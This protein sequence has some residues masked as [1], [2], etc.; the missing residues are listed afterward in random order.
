MSEPR[1]PL[2]EAASGGAVPRWVRCCTIA[3]V[4]VGCVL[5]FAGISSKVIWNDE[6]HTGQ[7][8][9]GATKRELR[10]RVFDGRARSRDEVLA[11]QFP[12]SG[13][14]AL[15]TVAVLARDDPKHPPLYFVTVRAWMQ[16]FGAS[17]GV[18]RSLSAVFGVVALPLL[19][20][21]CR[22]LAGAGVAPW[23]AVALVSVSPIHLVYAQEARQYTLW[24]DLVLLASWCL[25]RGVRCARADG[26]VAALWFAGHAM[27]LALAFYTHLLTAGVA[28]AH[29]LFVIGSQRRRATR[30]VLLTAASV[31][32]AGLLFSPWGV[33][34][35]LKSSGLGSWGS[36][37]SGS[38][39]VSLWLAKAAGGASKVFVD[40]D[41]LHEQ[42][43]LL[44]T[45][46]AGGVLVVAA[47]SALYGVRAAGRDARWFL[48]AL[49]AGH[50]APFVA[51]DLVRGGS[52]ATIV[53]Y[54]F[55]SVL[56]WELLVAVGISTLLVAGKPSLRRIGAVTAGLL[57]ACGIASGVLH[58]RAR[59]WWN[60]YYGEQILAVAEYL[61]T[62]PEPLVVIDVSD[63]GRGNSLAL[64]HA[65]A[66]GV[67][68]CYVV[69]EVAPSIPEREEAA[70]AWGMSSTLRSRLVEH[71]WQVEPVGTAELERLRSA[72]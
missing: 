56:A 68:M 64:A 47:L 22:E 38:V 7:V 29:C 31:V 58:S 62:V 20:L 49:A 61:E 14:T 66:D 48:L 54:L 42:A 60:K 34:L 36:W 24:I 44:F 50:W 10:Q 23:V 3:L 71:G 9:S 46:V 6:T 59:V 15:D 33:V 12:R 72:E 4:A 21:L 30:A 70:L 13:A 63:R 69:E 27:A 57:V 26:R 53:R 35:L 55:P 39:P 16:A 17:L 11:Y 37:A 41:R 32:A 43:V 45:V 65:V 5:R 51:S 25:V 28:F 18:M 1:E 19:F 8:A 2:A 40:L 52:R 67:R